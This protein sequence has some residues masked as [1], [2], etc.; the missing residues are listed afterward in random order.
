MT[1]KARSISLELGNKV[2]LKDISFDVLPGEVVSVIGPNGAGKTSLLNILTGN[3]KC[4]S[5]NV[6]YLS[7]IHI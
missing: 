5:G 1:I 7:L 6:M 3:I 2:I 4:S